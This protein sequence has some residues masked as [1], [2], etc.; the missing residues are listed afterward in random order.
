[1]S[2][3][4]PKTYMPN[5][6]ESIVVLKIDHIVRKKRSRRTQAYVVYAKLLVGEQQSV[7]YVQN[8]LGC[9]HNGGSGIWLCVCATHREAK[10]FETSSLADEASR[11]PEIF[12]SKCNDYTSGRGIVLGDMGVIS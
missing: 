4:S 2:Q 9:R 3:K 10:R 7:S 1:M 11:N 8:R 6:K 5:E 12:C